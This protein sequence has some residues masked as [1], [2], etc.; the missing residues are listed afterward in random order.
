MAPEKWKLLSILTDDTL[1]GVLA[2][3]YDHLLQH[4]KYY[5]IAWGF[6]TRREKRKKLCAGQKQNCKLQF[7][8]NEMFFFSFS[9]RCFRNAGTLDQHLTKKG[10]RELGNYLMAST[11]PHNKYN[12]YQPNGYHW[13]NIH[14]KYQNYLAINYGTAEGSFPAECGYIMGK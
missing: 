7:N 13:T 5:W 3:F 6:F 8:D 11:W 12:K 14:K 4:I 2:L 10:E 1:Q 9:C